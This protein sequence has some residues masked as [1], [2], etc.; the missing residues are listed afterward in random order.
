MSIGK[1]TLV[2]SLCHGGTGGT[3]AAGARSK[4]PPT[5]GCNVDVK[6]LARGYADRSIE[7]WDVGGNPDAALARGMFFEDSEAAG[8]LLV[9]DVSNPRSLREL[10]GW[11]DELASAGVRIL[12]SGGNMGA[13]SC[14]AGTPGASEGG[15][16]LRHQDRE[17]GLESLT[18]LEGGSGGIGGAA[19][20]VPFLMVGTKEEMGEGVRRSGARLA[21]EL[22]MGHVAV[23]ARRLDNDEHFDRF[24]SEVF[25]HHTGR[26]MPGDDWGAL[27]QEGVGAGAGAG[28]A[29]LSSFGKSGIDD[30]D[31]FLEGPL[32]LRPAAS[33]AYFV[34]ARRGRLRAPSSLR[35]RWWAPPPSGR[36]CGF[37]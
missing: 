12:G 25:R 7:F 30:D 24:F 19:G 6:L 1:T 2:R 33:D 16:A 22:G 31:M 17:D 21:A 4:A 15:T 26:H 5:I 28:A 8:V 13:R 37:A 20:A 9:Y 29:P 27:E 36:K 18:D 32:P 23:C 3:A 35:R 11:T 34:L 14:G 10:R